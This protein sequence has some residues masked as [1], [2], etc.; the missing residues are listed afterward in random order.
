MRF[1]LPSLLG[2]LAGCAAVTKEAGPEETAS[3]G[4]DDSGP[5]DSGED[6]TTPEPVTRVLSSANL[7]FDGVNV[8]DR[9]GRY[10][11]AAGDVDGDGRPD[12][13]FGSDQGDSGKSELPGRV[14][15]V[16]ASSLPSSGTVE[17]G[18]A[19]HVYMGEE[20][21]D[22]AG[23]SGGHAGDMDG[24]GYGEV[25]IS[26]YH[27]SDGGAE[28]GRIYILRGGARPEPGVTLLADAD[29]TFGGAAD[30]GRLGHGLAGVGDVD[31]DGLDDVLVG[32][33][34]GEPARLGA[35]WMVLGGALGATGFTEVMD[36]YPRWDGAALGD[37]AG[38]KTAAAG[39][40]DGDGL[41][42]ALVSARL[43]TGV[44]PGGRV[45]LI[46]GSAVQ[47][48]A[49]DELAALGQQFEGVETYGE[50]GY[51]IGAA[52]DVDGDGLGDLLMGAY[53]ASS[54]APNSGV[55][56]L[57]LARDLTGTSV[58]AD[59]AWLQLTSS[60]ENQQAG[61]SVTGDM[62]VDGDSLADFVIGASGVSPPTLEGSSTD[63]ENMDS[64]G[65]AYL[66]LGARLEGGV[67]DVKTA[68]V[69]VQGETTNDHAGI[70]VANPGDIDGDGADDLLV[71]GER[72]QEGVGRA[73]LLYG[74]Y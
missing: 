49:A 20:H 28:Q 1:V 14:Y 55:V 39:D 4:S 8:G 7:T 37:G 54:R 18:E 19:S 46:P 22:M 13:Y 24:D 26:A 74:L 33:C 6:D 58:Y 57:F 21:G 32:E 27:V 69:H 9:A 59:T 50:L 62:N 64:P 53:H 68:T 43:S 72:G 16:P 31:G 38:V 15:V 51:S 36:V 10:V 61:V 66:F 60:V 65:D 11:A 30:Y 34:C 3:G 73:W 48:G 44:M 23:H 67:V 71:G 41:A 5:I 63:T 17:L 2:A 25:V 56:Y 47:A 52:G 35:A 42:D 45:Y 70:S 29:W 12:L 40:V